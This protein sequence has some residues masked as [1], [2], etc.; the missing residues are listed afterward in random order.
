MRSTS[1]P[2]SRPAWVGAMNALTGTGG[3]SRKSPVELVATAASV[4]T[5]SSYADHVVM[6]TA[7]IAFIAAGAFSGFQQIAHRRAMRDS[8]G[9]S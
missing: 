8:I 2:V 5:H 7:D 1:S 9:L 4:V 3:A 6:S